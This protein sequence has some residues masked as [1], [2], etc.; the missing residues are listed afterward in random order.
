MGASVFFSSASEL[1]TVSNTFFV[2]T[3]PTNPTNVTLTITS[4]SNVVTTPTPTS[5]GAGAYTADI[6]CDEDGTWQ[7]EWVGTG[8]AVDTQV[9]TW[10]VF[11]TDLGKLYCPI[12]ALKSRLG[13]THDNADFELHA[14]CFAASRW[15]EQHT[16]RVFWRS[17]SQSRTFE[18]DC[19]GSVLLPAFCD[20]VSVSAV[21]TDTAGD[22]TFATTLSAGAYRLLPYN[23]AAAPENLPYNEVRLTGGWFPSGGAGRPDSVQIT[24]IWGWPK[25]PSAIRQAAAIIAADTYK[26]KDSPFGVAGEGEFTVQVGE[27]KRALRYLEPYKRTAVLVA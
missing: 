12:E 21:K 26:L 23:P 19:G 22:G 3:T 6:T 5:T 16:E 8:A 7:Y 25:V 20:L 15:I 27:N 24:G 18:P 4:P 14:A 10:D 17:L 9:G 13:I 11:E 2:G 1:A